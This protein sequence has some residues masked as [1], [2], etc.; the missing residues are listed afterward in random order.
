[1]SPAAPNTPSL[2]RETARVVENRRLA[3]DQYLMRL[4]APAT[5]AGARPGHFVHLVCGEGFTLPR[6]FSILDADSPAGTLD[7]LYRV[8]GRGTSAMAAWT[9]GREAPLLGPAGR[10]FTEP[11]A[12]ATLV[13]VAGGVGLAPLDFLARRAQAR[14]CGVT[15]FLGTESLPPFPTRTTQTPLAGVAA[16]VDLALTRYPED[17]AVRLA[18]LRPRPGFYQGYVTGLARAHLAALEDRQRAGIRLYSCGP[19]PMMAAVARLGAEFG[20]WGEVSLEAHM[21]C[22]FGGCAGCAAPMIDG[23]GPDAWRYRRVC[24]EGPVFAMAEVAWHRFS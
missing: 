6:P 3:G 24:A 17:L 7:L 4:Q 2:Q 13:L 5:A 18:A 20:L 1:M 16:D 15:L 19:L 11:A 21:A 12:G 10:P 23:E 8:V 22:G 14:G 9:P